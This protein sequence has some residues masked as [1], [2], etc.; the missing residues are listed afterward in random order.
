MLGSHTSV[1]LDR[2]E[3]EAALKHFPL[4][5]RLK[6]TPSCKTSHALFCFLKW[7]SCH[8]SLPGGLWGKKKLLLKCHL[9]WFAN[10]SQLRASV[11]A[12]QSVMQISSPSLPFC[13][14]LVHNNA[15][16][17]VTA[18]AAAAAEGPISCVHNVFVKAGQE[19][20]RAH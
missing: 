6:Q 14:E 5:D 7:E 15:L 16:D 3:T 11:C 8:V 17:S 20:I 10:Q 19:T 12:P 9:V 1:D 4:N 18:A 2:L 13:I